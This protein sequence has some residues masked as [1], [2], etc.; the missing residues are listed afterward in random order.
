MSAYERGHAAGTA[1]LLA[2]R[3]RSQRD[4]LRHGDDYF[5]GY[6]DAMGGM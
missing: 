2:G 6:S 1:D 5:D 4:V 3:V